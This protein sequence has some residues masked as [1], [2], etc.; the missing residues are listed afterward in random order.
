MHA[1]WHVGLC[2]SIT[3]ECR[4]SAVE[5]GSILGHTSLAMQGWHLSKGQIVIHTFW[6]NVQAAA[7]ATQGSGYSGIRVYTRPRA[8][9]SHMHMYAYLKRK[10]RAVLCTLLLEQN[11]VRAQ[12]AQ[13]YPAAVYGAATGGRMATAQT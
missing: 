5:I 11:I 3:S 9:C 6:Q 8:G 1:L 4:K 12:E 13:V 10:R 2:P 7:A